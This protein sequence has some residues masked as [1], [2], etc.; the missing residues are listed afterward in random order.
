[1]MLFLGPLPEFCRGCGE[2]E[3][4]SGKWREGIALVW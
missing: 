1:M 2:W 4:G 3:V